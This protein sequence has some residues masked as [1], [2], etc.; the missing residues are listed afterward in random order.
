M[1]ETTWNEAAPTE[2]RQGVSGLSASTKSSP[3][4]SPLPIP[5]GFL[6]GPCPT[7]FVSLGQDL[8]YGKSSVNGKWMEL[9]PWEKTSGE[10][11]RLCWP[12]VLPASLG[13]G[14][15]IYKAKPESAQA[16]VSLAATSAQ[17]G[18]IRA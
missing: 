1:F 18:C 14:S 10:Q 4:S 2:C 6:P 17:M 13:A 7:S 15:L 16:S 9:E 3:F 12:P 8:I 5:G 11:N